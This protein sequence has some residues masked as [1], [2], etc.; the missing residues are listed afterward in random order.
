MLLRRG[1]LV[2][3]AAAALLE[4]AP[5]VFGVGGA[6][7]LLAAEVFSDACVPKPCS[8]CGASFCFSC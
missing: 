1:L 5:P 7:E 6:V 3:L 8:A 2:L 4:D